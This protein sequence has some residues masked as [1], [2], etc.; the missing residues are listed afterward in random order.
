LQSGDHIRYRSLSSVYYSI[1]DTAAAGGTRQ[2]PNG[3]ATALGLNAS[4]DE[5]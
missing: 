3:E 2:E 5:P 1:C 4:G